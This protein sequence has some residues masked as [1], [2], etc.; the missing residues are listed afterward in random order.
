V[1]TKSDVIERGRTLSDLKA[2]DAGGLFSEMVSRRD[3]AQRHALTIGGER[4]LG[5]FQALDS[6]IGWIEDEIAFG[7]K[8]LKKSQEASS[9]EV[10]KR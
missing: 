5:M 8:E 4:T 7:A 2:V 9:G 10:V 1:T 6:L 3:A